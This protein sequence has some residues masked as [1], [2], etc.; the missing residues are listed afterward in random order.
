MCF[1][2]ILEVVK[3]LKFN[4][5]EWG[6]DDFLRKWVKKA[7]NHQ[8]KRVRNLFSRLDHVLVIVRRGCEG[9]GR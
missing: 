8:N 6:F 7:K 4:K 5:R 1:I 3:M 2:Y 9:F